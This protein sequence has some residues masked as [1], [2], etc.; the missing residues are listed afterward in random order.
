MF[1]SL[2]SFRQGLTGEEVHDAK[3]RLHSN[4]GQLGEYC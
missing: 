3:N 1:R 2:L 4:I